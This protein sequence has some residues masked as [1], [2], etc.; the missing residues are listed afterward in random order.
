SDGDGTVISASGILSVTVDTAAPAAPVISAIATDSGSSGSDG[1][2][3]D[4]TLVIS[5]TAEANSTV[6][7]FK[8]GVSIGTTT[9]NGSGNWSFEDRKSARR[10]GRYRCTV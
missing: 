9:A 1:I 6:Q 2:T 4:K 3:N 8:D 5:G 10:E 7:V